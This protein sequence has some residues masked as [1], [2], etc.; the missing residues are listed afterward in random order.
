MTMCRIAVAASIVF[1]YPLTFVGVREG[2]FD[3]MNIPTAKRTK[4]AVTRMTLAIMSVVTAGALVVKD[5][6]LVLALGGAVLGNALIFVF[7][8]MMF[9][10]AFKDDASKAGERKVCAGI[11]AFGIVMGCVGVVKSLS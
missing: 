9:R 7:P 2:V 11:S 5:L 10:N 3:L 4:G 1:S 6:S 8:S